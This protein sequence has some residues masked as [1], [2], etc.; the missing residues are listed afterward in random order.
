MTELLISSSI[1]IS[2]LAAERLLLRR[3]IPPGL[4]YALWL[5]VLLRLMLPFS[6][7]ASPVSAAGAVERLVET[8][9]ETAPAA[10]VTEARGWGPEE[11]LPVIWIAGS[12]VMGVWFA[13]VELR[14]HR[15]LRR[16]RR[17]L[18]HRG[19]LPVYVSDELTSPCLHGIFHPAVYLTKPAAEDPFR[20]R[21]AYIHEFTHWRHRDHL[22]SAARVLC[23][24]V[25]WFDPFVWLAAFLSK[26]DGEL[27]CDA[28]SIRTLG[29]ESRFAYGRALLELNGSPGRSR[30]GFGALALSGGAKRLRE[31]IAR[32]AYGRKAAVLP[33]A[34][35][36]V[37]ILAAAGCAFSSPA[38]ESVSASLSPLFVTP[39]PIPTPTPLGAAVSAQP[40]SLPTPTPASTPT[41]TPLPTAATPE[42]TPTVTPFVQSFR[43]IPAQTQEEPTPTPLRAEPTAVPDEPTPTMPSTVPDSP[44]PDMISETPVPVTPAVSEDEIPAEQEDADDPE[45]AVPALTPPTEENTEIV[46]RDRRADFVDSEPPAPDMPSTVPDS[47]P[48]TMPSAVPDSLPPA[49][50]TD[51][52]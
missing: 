6:L 25:Y 10:P 35:A 18:T 13:A 11:I 5:L 24:V 1:L 51:E 33:T 43:T 28:A 16:S 23:L 52:P 45:I 30:L 29:E 31:R 41:P 9:A 21:I 12:C 20:A 47:P 27:Y 2:V 36:A 38:A 34:A 19:P 4:Q 14:L 7:V 50:G 37:I 26:Q 46:V 17:C 32:L 42:P 39:T 3:R 40:E 48:P 22:W 49:T 15:R 44:P 8:A